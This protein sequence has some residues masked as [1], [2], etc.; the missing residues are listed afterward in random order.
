M[1]NI[2]GHGCRFVSVVQYRLDVV[3]VIV[4]IVVVFH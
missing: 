3:M 4:E 1:T 2:E